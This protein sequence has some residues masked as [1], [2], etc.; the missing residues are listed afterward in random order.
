MSHT[1]DRV[2]QRYIAA[3]QAAGFNVTSDARFR[4]PAWMV[5]AVE[6]RKELPVEVLNIWKYCA[7]TILKHGHWGEKAYGA[8]LKH[9]RH[10]CAKMA[11]ALPQKYIEGGGGEGAEG[12]WKVH[13]GEQIEDWVK[14][15]LI[16]EC[17]HNDLSKTIH[18]WQMEI[19]HL[20]R[21]IAECEDRVMT[22]EE[23]IQTVKTDK[24]YAQRL[25]WLNGA[26]ADLDD[27]S[28]QLVKAREA[29][30]A[31]L[32]QADRHKNHQIPAEAFEREFQKWLQFASEELGDERKAI[33]AMQ[34]AI[35]TFMAN[36]PVEA[37]GPE[38]QRSKEAGVIDWLSGLAQ[39]AWNFVVNAFDGIADWI[40]NLGK[41]TKAIESMM[42]E[43]GA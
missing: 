32:E 41:A 39:K 8:C 43:A 24:G 42:N 3:K 28:K 10:K 36:M 12:K 14:A 20:E 40:A 4:P 7:E 6:E 11:I 5:A 29:A 16:S 2:L 37:A 19:G 35:D 18:D 9:W 1:A 13:N 15:T 21:E 26:K 17:L 27:F 25:K 34:K 31:L 30:K 33:H 22:H 23:K 38:T